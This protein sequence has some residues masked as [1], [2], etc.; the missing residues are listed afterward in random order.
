MSRIAN[1]PELVAE[2]LPIFKHE[3]IECA[4]KPGES[5]ALLSDARTNP[6][7]AAA[8]FA[9]AKELDALCFQI[10]VPYMIQSTMQ[11]PRAHG[12]D[13]IS[14]KG[15]LQALMAADLVI[16]I[17]SFG[18]LYTHVH[19][20]ILQSGTR[21]LM[22]RQPEEVLRRLLPNADVRRRAKAGAEVLTAGKRIRISH[23][24]GTDLHF[25]ING[26]TALFQYGASDI[27]GRWDHWPSGHAAIAP[28]ESDTEGVLVLN[29]GDA[30]LRI[31]RYF[32]HPITLRFEG[33]RLVAIEGEHGDAV[34]LRDQFEQWKTEKAYIPAHIGWGC[35][36]RC[37]WA[38][39]SY[40]SEPWPSGTMDL[41]SAYGNIMFGIGSNHFLGLG[42][43]NDTAAHIDFCIRNYTFEV[44]DLVVLK[45]GQIV[46]DE[47]K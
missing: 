36:H 7:Y 28:L 42:G 30:V 20:K 27:P 3:L 14:D 23:P 15:P 43:K 9:A 38:Q 18:W 37:N 16:D 10:K 39:L 22:V 26:R 24:N 29:P 25:N 21:T 5:I 40:R 4:V 8:F 34:L 1:D 13:A 46:P 19:N 11:N 2:L 31:E 45:D 47:L 35:D 17:A 41:E 6:F 12:E 32:M 33:G 44:D